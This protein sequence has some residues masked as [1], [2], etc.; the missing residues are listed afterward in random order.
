MI[1]TAVVK[2]WG[3]VI[4]AVSLDDSQKTAEFE[5]DRNFITSGIQ[6]SPIIMPLKSG[7]YRFP[8]LSYESFYGLP[9]LLADSLPDRFGNELI[10]LWLSKQG[11]LPDSFNAVERLCY[12]GKRGMGA[13]E[14]EPAVSDTNDEDA[15]VHIS[16]LVELASIVLSNRQNLTAV[17]D[18]CDKK[19]LSSSIQKIIKLGTSAGGA[20]A[21]AVIAWNPKTN[22]VRSGQ[23][24]TS[25]GFE[26]WLIKFS[27]VAGNKD[28]EDEDREDFG[29]IEYIY[30]LTA[31]E[32]GI[33]MSKCR[34]LDDGKNSHFMTKR[35]DR[36][37]RGNKFHMQTLCALAHFDFNQAGLY[38]YEQLFAILNQI[39]AHH[40]D[41]VEA[42]RRMLFNIFAFNCD[43]HTKNISFLMDKSGQ[44]SLAPAYD[45][46]FAY[47]PNGLWTSSHQMTVNGKRKNFTENDFETCAKIGNLT[48]REVMSAMEDV[49]AG[50][51]K[52]KKLAKDAGLSEKRINEIW[53]LIGEGM[54]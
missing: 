29:I 2:L 52:W 9:G 6:V 16:E 11:R 24:E 46:S 23:T 48:S 20:R 10:N 39:G 27:G 49:R 14:F 53:E 26:H 18:E 15:A 43:D 37:D 12:T 54:I 8:E 25:K 35:F 42:F 38:S 51:S 44:W 41:S 34:I 4:G 19:N 30:Y 32:A 1:N 3:T 31:R 21:K 13:L 28:K 33:N 17:F 40:R 22:E 36:D 47:N 45:L 50:I 7:V 5:Y